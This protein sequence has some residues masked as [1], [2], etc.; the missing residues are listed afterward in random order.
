MLSLIRG[1]ENSIK[2]EATLEELYRVFSRVFKCS[3]IRFNIVIVS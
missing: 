1:I 2:N 3:E